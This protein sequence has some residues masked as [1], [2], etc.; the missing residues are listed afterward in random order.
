VVVDA[1]DSAVVGTEE[2]IVVAMAAATVGGAGSV[3]K[4]GHQQR[5]REAKTRNL[6]ATVAEREGRAQATA[7]G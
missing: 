6:S 1:V 4:N 3:G 2:A 7:R 5:R